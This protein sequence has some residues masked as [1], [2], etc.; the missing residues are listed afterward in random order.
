MLGTC[1]IAKWTLLTCTITCSTVDQALPRHA[2]EREHFGN[3]Q[4]NNGSA[5]LSSSEDERAAA[6]GACSSALR[7][8]GGCGPAP[9]GLLPLRLEADDELLLCFEHDEPLCSGPT[10]TMDSL[11]MDC[12]KASPGS[13]NAG[14]SSPGPGFISTSP[15]NATSGNHMLLVDAAR[16]G[17]CSSVGR[18]EY[19][20]KFSCDSRGG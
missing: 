2:A 1:W 16:K 20:N 18:G 19:G 6:S 5:S 9:S 17:S 8:G 4:C 3:G 11:R 12:M 10:S 7:A 13:G 14:V 15:S